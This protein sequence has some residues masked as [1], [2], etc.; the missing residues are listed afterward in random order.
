MWGTVSV[1]VFILLLTFGVWKS[2]SSGVLREMIEFAKL[3]ILIEKDMFNGET[4]TFVFKKNGVEKALKIKKPNDALNSITSSRTSSGTI[5]FDPK[6]ENGLHL[7]FS[8]WLS[9]GVSLMT[10]I[11]KD[12]NKIIQED[13]YNLEEKGLMPAVYRMI[14]LIERMSST[15]SVWDEFS[16]DKT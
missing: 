6:R 12:G 15:S 16:S 5:S 8:M 3:P 7:E 4:K 13:E 11:E 1:I 2:F 9:G 10:I 14:D